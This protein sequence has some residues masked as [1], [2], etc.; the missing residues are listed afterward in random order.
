MSAIEEQF[1]FN[2]D[3]T[4]YSSKRAAY[5]KILD[6]DPSYPNRTL[7]TPCALI[8]MVNHAVSGGNNE[9]IGTCIGQVNTRDFYINDV[10]SSSVL[11]TETNCDIS[12]AVWSQLIE[13]SKS[14]AKT[15]K[16][17]TGCCAW[18]HS[19]PDYGCW[20]SATDVIAQRQM[21]LGSTR[22]CALV[23]DP[24]KTERH[25]RIFLGSFRTFPPDKARGEKSENS[26]VPDGKADDFKK[27][28]SQYYTLS[29]E[30]YLSQIDRKVLKD[31][32]T[33][34]WGRSLAQSPLEANSE[35]IY[36]YVKDKIVCSLGQAYLGRLTSKAD[37]DLFTGMLNEIDNARIRGIE[38][39]KMKNHVFLAK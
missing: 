33:S 14:V 15:G 27:S 35:W 20:L 17:A 9:I 12:S 36:N 18:Y 29:I 23:V 37:V 8:S 34:T 10:F 21:Q 1:F 26:F 30:Y 3:P 39:Q 7:V 5:N 31:V 24:K 22:T 6:G 28:L 13:V 2:F 32:I 4:E 25:N 16:K 38:I 11:G 19:H